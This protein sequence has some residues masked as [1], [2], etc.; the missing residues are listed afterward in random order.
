LSDATEL[1]KRRLSVKT[2]VA[3]SLMAV[4][5]VLVVI[6][7][8]TKVGS[9]TSSLVGKRVES[10]SLPGLNGG[11]ED[12]PWANGH[13]AVLIFFASWCIPCQGEMPKV[14]A[15]ISTHPPGKVVVMGIDST[16]AQ[17]SAQAFT[18][19]NRVTFPVAFDANNAVTSGIFKFGQIP[20]TVFVDGS[21]TVKQVYFG[22]IPVG[23]LSSGI[24]ALRKL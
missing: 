24:G 10:Y 19:K 16:N 8:N 1:R 17:S 7:S 11:T 22:A 20:E 5:T 14:A 3:L 18:R 9:S 12:A 6:A 2:W 21:G 23:Q 13:P 4:L 15:Y